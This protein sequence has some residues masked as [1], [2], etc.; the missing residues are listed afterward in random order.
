MEINKTEISGII[1]LDFIKPYNKNYY[2]SALIHNLKQ[3]F[4]LQC[5]LDCP[6]IELLKKDNHVIVSGSMILINATMNYSAYNLIHVKSIQ[7]YNLL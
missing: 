1:T 7:E 5:P 6:G 2:E 4:K 3:R